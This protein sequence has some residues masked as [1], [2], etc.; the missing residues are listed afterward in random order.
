VR[1]IA[2]TSEISMSKTETVIAN[3]VMNSVC[4]VFMVSPSDLKGSSRHSSIITARHAYVMLRSQLSSPTY[5]QIGSELNGRSHSTVISSLRKSNELLESDKVFGLQCKTVM[6]QLVD[7]DN[8]VVRSL[9]RATQEN[10]ESDLEK[11]AAARKLMREFLTTFEG[12]IQ[13]HSPSV[14]LKKL[15]GIREE[16][17]DANLND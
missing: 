1:I 4:S 17:I 7:S 16:A 5:T 8:V 11:A 2:Q 14:V 6:D 12:F 9:A 15:H 3:V 10:G 13:G